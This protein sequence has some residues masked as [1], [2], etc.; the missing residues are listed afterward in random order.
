MTKK[1]IFPVTR[2]HE[3]MRVDIEI[4][5]D[6]VTDA[7]ISATMF[8]G[9]E[10]MMNGRDPRD[11]ALITQRICGICTVAHAVAANLAQQQAFGV[12]TTPN[13][14]LL[15][16]LIFAADIIH[17]HL[18]HFYVLGLFDYV[19]GPETA[20]YLP[21]QKGDFRLPS[22]VNNKIIAHAQM[23]YVMAARAHEALAV[24]GAKAPMQQTI[25]PTG[26][27]EQANAERIMVYSSILEEIKA[28]VDNVYVD[29]VMTIADYYDDYYNIGAG[30]GNFLSYGI[31]PSPVTG[32]LASRAGVVTNR[33]MVEQLDESQIS[34]AV[35]FSWYADEAENRRPENGITVPDRN[36]PHAY[37]WI[38]APRYQGRTYESGPLARGWISGDYRRGI[39]VMDRLVARTRETQK[40]CQLA[41]EW[42]AQLVPGAPTAQP[43]TTPAQGSGAGLTDAMRGALGHWF[44]YEDNKIDHYQIITP[45][46]WNFSPRDATGQRGAVEEALIGTPIA[47]IDSLIE[48]GRVIRSLDPCFTCA[49]HI[50]NT[51]HRQPLIL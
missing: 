32:K 24:F 35:Q 21:R 45:T 31:F 22:A 1:V 5:G 16:N 26:V 33:G 11:A 29:D 7:W 38:K 2:L 44:S 4:E 6:K 46:T 40:I 27:T 48:V 43:Y 36:K 30:N 47:N 50:Y 28:F 8:R 15:I 20:P 13:G 23:A 41:E 12:K 10:P 17:N 25:L 51:Q 9:F 49:V 14:Q 42:L 37:S 19:V 39:S 18:L 34:E 3:P